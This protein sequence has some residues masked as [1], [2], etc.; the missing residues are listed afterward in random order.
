MTVTLLPAHFLKEDK[1]EPGKAEK[2]E[3][4]HPVMT[5]LHK[6]SIQSWI[7]AQNANQ[8]KTFFVNEVL[9][10]FFNEITMWEKKI[11]NFLLHFTF[12]FNIKQNK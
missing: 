3:S 11:H 1:Q 2:D 6:I 10:H 8:T 7:Q 5:D 9:I 12:Y 4:S